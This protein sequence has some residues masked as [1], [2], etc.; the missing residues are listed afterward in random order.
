MTHRLQNQHVAIL[1]ADGFEQAELQG[2]LER[3]TEAGA[4][5]CIISPKG[6]CIQGMHHAEKG[7]S[8]DVD[9]NIDSAK[10][11]DFSALVIPGGLMNPDELRANP[12]AVAFVRK[13]HAEGKP[14]A[15]ICHGPWVLIDAGLAH[16]R[17]LTS[18]PSIQTDIRNAGG[19]W[20]DQQVVVDRGIITSRNPDDV[21]AFTEAIMDALESAPVPV[22]VY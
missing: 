11:D 20:V 14:I 7:D 19:I 13:F 2:P 9:M 17:K 10:P 6:D 8:F 5:V 12:E 16:G 4:D 3:L 21:P 22:P 1:A 15:A 18:Y